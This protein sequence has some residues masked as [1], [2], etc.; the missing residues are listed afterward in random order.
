MVKL[1]DIMIYK[2]TL[3]TIFGARL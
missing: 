2:H 3:E 1:S